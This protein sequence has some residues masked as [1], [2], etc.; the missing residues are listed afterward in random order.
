MT[1]KDC[2]IQ[3][4]SR[5]V[6]TICSNKWKYSYV[7]RWW[8]CNLNWPGSM[9]SRCREGSAETPSRGS[10]RKDRSSP[11]QARFQQKRGGG[12]GGGSKLASSSVCAALRGEM[13]VMRETDLNGLPSAAHA[14][15]GVWLTGNCDWQAVSRLQLG[16][17][18]SMSCMN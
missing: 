10:A 7:W 17:I 14:V 2:F 16:C 3:E 4:R 8:L 12:W 15:I 13:C 1:T 9:L 18:T 5:H 11:T 6:L